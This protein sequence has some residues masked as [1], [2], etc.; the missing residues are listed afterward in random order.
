V[1]LG[2]GSHSVVY[3]AKLQGMDVAV[4]VCRPSAR[5]CVPCRWCCCCGARIRVSFPALAIMPCQPGLSSLLPF[6]P[7]PD[8][9]CTALQVCELL[10]GT[11]SRAIWREVSILRSCAHERIVPLFGVALKVWRAAC[12]LAA[13]L[14][15]R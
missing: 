3:L 8:L 7:C 2:A 13:H 4:K 9:H 10:P 6:L 5:G 14:V 12:S 15:V 1:E 11:D